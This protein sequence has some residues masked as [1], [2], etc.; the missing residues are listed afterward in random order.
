LQALFLELVSHTTLEQLAYL[1]LLSGDSE[2][3][4]ALLDEAL[5]IA[6]HINN[7]WVSGHALFA[8]AVIYW[9]VRRT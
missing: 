9:I 5:A 8:R 1:L 3:T 7:P 4:V 6:Q 2:R